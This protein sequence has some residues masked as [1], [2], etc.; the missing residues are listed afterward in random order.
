M[1]DVVPATQSQNN[2]YSGPLYSGQCLG[3]NGILIFIS[4]Y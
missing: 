2:N 3:A 1:V 4:A